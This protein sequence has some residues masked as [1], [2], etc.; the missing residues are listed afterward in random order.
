MNWFSFNAT[1]ILKPRLVVMDLDKIEW[2]S[3]SGSD[4][5]EVRCGGRSFMMGFETFKR[6][7]S[8][9]SSATQ[10]DIDELLQVLDEEPVAS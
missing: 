10:E 5:I 1:N 7:L 2:V 4:S 9:L 6:M 3:R 8:S